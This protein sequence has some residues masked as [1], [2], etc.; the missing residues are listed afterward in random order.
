MLEN[1]EVGLWDSIWINFV[2]GIISA[3][4]AVWFTDVLCGKHGE[5][6]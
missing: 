1:L 2:L 4:L 3:W 5:K 6:C